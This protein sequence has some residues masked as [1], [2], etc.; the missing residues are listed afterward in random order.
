M[1][2]KKFGVISAA[3]YGIYYCNSRVY[4]AARTAGGKHDFHGVSPLLFQAASRRTAHDRDTDSTTPISNSSISIAVPPYEK[5]GS[6]IPVF[7]IVS[8]T[9]IIFSIVWIATCDTIPITT[10]VANLSFVRIAI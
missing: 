7:G 10:S 4:M 8:V 5:N 9:T 6:A 3:L 1:S 2:I